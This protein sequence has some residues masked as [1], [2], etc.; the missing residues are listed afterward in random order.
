MLPS[1]PGG[2]VAVVVGAVSVVVVVA[3]EVVPVSVFAVDPLPLAQPAIPTIALVAT[4]IRPAR[5]SPRRRA[6][7]S[8]TFAD[9]AERAVPQKGHVAS[10]IL[11][12]RSQ[13][14]QSSSVGMAQE[15]SG[16]TTWEPQTH[17]TLRRSGVCE[18]VARRKG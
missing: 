6:A 10:S 1:S 12:C 5:P 8:G 4:A 13:P 16:P 18:Q 9:P 2:V 11:T 15:Y 17:A 3:V 14:E 7:A